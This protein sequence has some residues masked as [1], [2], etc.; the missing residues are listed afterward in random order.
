[1]SQQSWQR[2]E[3]VQWKRLEA[4]LAQ[5]GTVGKRMP[6]AA[7]KEMAFLYRVVIN[8]LARVRSL[9]ELRHLEGYLNNLA[10]R[11]HGWVY[12]RPPVSSRDVVRFFLVDFP[13]C[14][15]KNVLLIALAFSMFALGSGL[16]IVTVKLDPQTEQYFLPSST[17]TA[18]DQGVLWTDNVEANPS[19]SSFLMTN[20]I[21]VAVNAFAAGI[22]LG[23]GT[24]AILLQNGLFAFGGPLAVCFQHG[25]GPR[26]LNFMVAHGVI[27]LSTIFIA[28]GAG[29]LIGF[30]ILF[31]GPYGRWEAVAKKSREALV[32][33]LGCFPLLVVA[34]LIEGMVSMNQHVSSPIR[35]LV[36]LLSFVALTAYFG[37]SGRGQESLSTIRTD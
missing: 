12:Q 34:G 23:I 2:E 27:E 26:L 20:N 14:F 13:A 1:M 6:P 10:Q 30:A 37:L 18:L 5:S 11:T 33:I 36:S 7:L 3:E 15:R 31:P 8:D 19:Q 28:G 32:L 16:A 17:I 35:V 9:P 4:L 29:M 25:M 24:L 21:R 22:L